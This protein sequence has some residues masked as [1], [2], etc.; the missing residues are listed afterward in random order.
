[1][2]LQSFSD[3]TLGDSTLS[4]LITATNYPADAQEHGNADAPAQELGIGQAAVVGSLICRS[5]SNISSC[6][7]AAGAAD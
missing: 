4:Q 5:N 7:A 1:M 2:E 6:L 3:G